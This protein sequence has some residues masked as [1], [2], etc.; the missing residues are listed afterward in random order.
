MLGYL[1]WILYTEE[2]KKNGSFQINMTVI[3]S[4]I[5]VSILFL[6]LGGFILI[7]NFTFYLFPDKAHFAGK[8]ERQVF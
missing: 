2:G 4:L 7:V 6:K 5:L 8:Y 3:L 1:N